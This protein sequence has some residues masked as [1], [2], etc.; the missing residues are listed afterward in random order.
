MRKIKDV[1]RLRFDLGLRRRG[2]CRTCSVGLGTAHEY[3]HRA[4]AAGV[5]WPLGEDWDEDRLE[6]AL[7]GDP[8]RSRQAMLPM[9]DFAELFRQRQQQ[10]PLTMSLFLFLF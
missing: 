4:E 5:T 8:P 2:I 3:L 7:F 10:P 1:L 9:P 6:A